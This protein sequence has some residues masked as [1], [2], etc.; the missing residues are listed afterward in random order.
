MAGNTNLLRIKDALIGAQIQDA[1][2]GLSEDLENYAT[3]VTQLTAE[4]TQLTAKISELSANV[5][6]SQR[7][8]VHVMSFMKHLECQNEHCNHSLNTVLSVVSKC[9]N[10]DNTLSCG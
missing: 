7:T 9:H 5:S 3:K 10:D 6:T 4:N 1:L 2:I 8:L